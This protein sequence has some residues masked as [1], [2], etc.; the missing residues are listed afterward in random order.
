M[1][2][3][4]IFQG[5][6]ILYTRVTIS[7]K[8]NKIDMW[9]TPEIVDHLIVWNAIVLLMLEDFCC[10]DVPFKLCDVLIFEVSLNL[11]RISKSE[12]FWGYLKYDLR[13]NDQKSVFRA[14]SSLGNWKMV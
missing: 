6:Q 1:K 2:L 8:A 14:I 4:F 9:D 5:C 12:L 10:L 3:N 13:E 11:E 7:Q